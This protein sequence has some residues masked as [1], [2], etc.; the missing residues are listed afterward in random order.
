M[1]KIS[2]EEKEVYKVLCSKCAESVIGD[3]DF[4]RYCGVPGGRLLHT[5]KDGTECYFT[6][7]DEDVKKIRVKVVEEV[8][9]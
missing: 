2:P 9:S 1:D 8:V 5:K 7:R 6:F 4:P 3:T